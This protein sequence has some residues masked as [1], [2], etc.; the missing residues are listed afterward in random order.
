MAFINMLK[1][2]NKQIFLNT[3][4]GMRKWKSIFA[5]FISFFLWQ[6]VRLAFPDL[7]VHPIYMYIYGLLE[8]RDSSQ[9]TVDLGGRRL[10]ANLTAFLVGLPMLAIMDLLK[11][12]LPEG[13]IY[14]LMELLFILI[15]T[16]ITI[17]LAQIMGC[18]TFCGVAAI[19]FIILVVSHSNDQRYI[20]CLLRAAQTVVAVFIAWLLNV[21]VFPYPGNEKQTEEIITEASETNH[22]ETEKPDK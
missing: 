9:K 19:I 5:I 18:K 15:G 8:I 6:L 22:N 20:Y 21:K 13:W 10:R 11:N 2:K 14:I 4:I 17:T 3:H 16:I 7:E 1:S 12:Y